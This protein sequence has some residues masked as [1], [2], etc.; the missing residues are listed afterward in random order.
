M[1]AILVQAGCTAESAETLNSAKA[2]RVRSTTIPEGTR[3]V[4]RTSS[5]LS[6]K[7][8]EAGEA[9]TAT[10]DQPLTL[11]GREIVS[12]GAQVEGKIVEADKGGRVDGLARLTVRLTGLQVGGQMVGVSTDTVTYV[13]KTSKGRDA[14][15]IA[16]GSGV[17]AAIGA[18]TGGGKGAA[19]G[20]AAGGGAGTGVVLATRGQAAEIPS[21]TLL[22]F[23]LLAPLTIARK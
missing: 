17:G 8:H 20:A 9:F 1:V 5:A 3:L 23:E 22:N 13:A 14:A 6:T 19:I 21:E 10:L 15:K 12:R 7:S 18:I 16:I 11:A 2:A 4:V